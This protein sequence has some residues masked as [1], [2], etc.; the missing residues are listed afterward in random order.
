MPLENPIGVT[1]ATRRFMS[2]SGP[3]SPHPARGVD[4]K[5]TAE[6]RSVSDIRRINRVRE[7]RLN[8]GLSLSSCRV[9]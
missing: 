2:L 4:P 7:H 1:T 3:A 5:Q 6:P 9:Q 8:F